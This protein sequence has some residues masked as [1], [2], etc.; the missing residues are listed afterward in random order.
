MLD[1]RDSALF[2]ERGCVDP[3]LEFFTEGSREFLSTLLSETQTKSYGMMVMW[4]KHLWQS[5]RDR[6]QRRRLKLGESRMT[7]TH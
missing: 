4:S 1:L 5:R 7:A 2:I 3:L 6:A